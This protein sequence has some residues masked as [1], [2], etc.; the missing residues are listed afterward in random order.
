[1]KIIEL[2]FFR[3]EAFDAAL[4]EDVINDSN[5]RQLCFAGVPEGKGRRASAWRVLLNFLPK[6]RG[7]WKDFLHQQRQLYA[8]L[9]G[10]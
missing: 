4:A 6:E 5:L 1:M 8:Q 10:K 2:Y 3:V 7:T 9:I